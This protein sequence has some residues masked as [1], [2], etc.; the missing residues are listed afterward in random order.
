MIYQL[1]MNLA[2]EYQPVRYTLLSKFI[3]SMN[4]NLISRDKIVSEIDIWNKSCV[5]K[6]SKLFHIYYQDD[7]L[8]FLFNKFQQS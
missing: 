3:D 2:L 7:P 5:L 8:S 6:I 1:K 4:S